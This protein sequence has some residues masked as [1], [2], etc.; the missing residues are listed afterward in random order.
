[1]T[2][3]DGIL[4]NNENIFLLGSTNLPWNLDAAILRRFE[5]RLFISLPNKDAR[6][7]LLKHYLPHPNNLQDQEFEYLASQTD[8]FS[9]SDMKNLCK[10]AAMC[11]VREKICEL[12]SKTKLHPNEQLRSITYGDVEQAFLKMKPCVNNC[13]KYIEWN[14]KYGAF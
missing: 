10:E 7:K 6:L 11:S 1:M 9:G 14:E 5:K 4:G 3:V 2:Q 8:N 12:K 13:T